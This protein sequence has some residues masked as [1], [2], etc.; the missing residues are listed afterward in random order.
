MVRT[1][2]G[3]L[4]Y[5]PVSMPLKLAELF[6]RNYVLLLRLTWHFHSKDVSEIRHV[7]D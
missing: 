4:K 5:F 1:I 6:L 2:K 7:G 3:I